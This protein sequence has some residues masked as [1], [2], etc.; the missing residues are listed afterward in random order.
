VRQLGAIVF[1]GPPDALLEI[2]LRLPAEQA[3]A[4]EHAEPLPTAPCGGIP[5]RA[6]LA[7]TASVLAYT[8][9][10]LVANA[11]VA[12]QAPALGKQILGAARAAA[13]ALSSDRP[14]LSI[15]ANSTPAPRAASSAG[16]NRLAWAETTA[17]LSSV[18]RSFH[19]DAVACGSR[20]IT[21]TV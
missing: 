16:F 14:A 5:R 17:G 11:Q 7:G 10:S 20:S 9:S 4:A 6:F 21:A 8:A 1:D 13:M 15:M 18:R 3:L 12:G 19:F 2:H